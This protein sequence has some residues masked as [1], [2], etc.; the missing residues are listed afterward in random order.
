MEYRGKSL[1]LAGQPCEL[2]SILKAADGLELPAHS[3][4]GSWGRKPFL[5]RAAAWCLSF[6]STMRW[7]SVKYLKIVR[8]VEE[9]ISGS[10]G[11]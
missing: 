9:E 3:I 10:D 8:S 1:S 7:V 4:P 2:E 11:T 6:G 5:D